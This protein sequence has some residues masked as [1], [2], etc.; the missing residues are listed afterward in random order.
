MYTDDKTL[1]NT[2]SP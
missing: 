1:F 2:D